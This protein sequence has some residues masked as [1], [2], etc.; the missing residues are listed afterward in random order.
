MSSIKY[1]LFVFQHLRG[2][3]LGKY[4]A[5]FISLRNDITPK[6]KMIVNTMSNAFVYNIRIMNSALIGLHNSPLKRQVSEPEPAILDGVGPSQTK[7]ELGHI[8]WP[9]APRARMPF[10]F[11][12]CTFWVIRSKV[13]FGPVTFFE[14]FMFK[15]LDW[16]NLDHHGVI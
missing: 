12:Q 11:L 10:A 15:S 4:A 16:Q 7:Q 9:R 8:G 5:V 1:N 13:V 6:F 14:S 2:V 3:L